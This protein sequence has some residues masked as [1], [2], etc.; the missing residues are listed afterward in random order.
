MLRAK[1][2]CDQSIASDFAAWPPRRRWHRPL[3]SCSWARGAGQAA[4]PAPHA[5][6]HVLRAPRPRPPHHRRT[7]RQRQ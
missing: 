6:S 1:T 4:M 3:V 5:W 2:R 7:T